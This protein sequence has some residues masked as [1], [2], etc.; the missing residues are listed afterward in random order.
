MSYKIKDPNTGEFITVAN[1]SRIFVGTTAAIDAAIA[2]GELK[3]PD[4]YAATDDYPT[5]DVSGDLVLASGVTIAAGGFARFEQSGSVVVFNFHGLTITP[6]GSD[7]TLLGNLPSNIGKPRRTYYFS[8]GNSSAHIMQIN[9]SGNVFLYSPSVTTQ[10]QMN[11][12]NTTYI[13]D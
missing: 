4:L 13:A 7:L 8:D 6:A 2:R 5:G 12:G 9:T 1:G 10:Q 11:A 3:F